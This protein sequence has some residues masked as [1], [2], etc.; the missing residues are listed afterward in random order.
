[1]SNSE[2]QSAA[3]ATRSP[4]SDSMNHDRISTDAD[5]TV[6]VSVE[7]EVSGPD[8]HPSPDPRSRSRRPARRSQDLVEPAGTEANCSVCGAPVALIHITVDGNVLVMES[9][10]SCDARRWRM[11]GRSISLNQVLD[12][13][14]VQADRRR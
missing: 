4:Q 2:M 7:P 13:V 12:E 6:E 14:G 1:M 10:D 8:T 5:P 3:T 11:E 9:C